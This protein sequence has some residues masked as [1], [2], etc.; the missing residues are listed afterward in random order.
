M[1]TS[2]LDR[3]DV[4]AQ[5]DQL[6][7]AVDHLTKP[8]VRMIVRDDG[9]ATTVRVPSL[10]SQALDAATTGSESSTPSALTLAER[11][12]VDLTLLEVR[13]LI[14]RCTRRWLLVRGL[15]PHESVP[16]QIRQL[17]S[18]VAT[19][20]IDDLWWW[21]YRLSSW[22]RLLSM[23]LRAG[24]HH[25]TPV[26]LRGAACPSCH[27]RRVLVDHGD[28][29]QTMPALVVDFAR[30]LVQAARCDACGATWWRGEELEHLATLLA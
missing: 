6:R 23:Y 21:E 17:A 28:G 27:A 15:V 16:L 29:P 20:E 4:A 8:D 19:H 26:R 14:A 9:T 13:E 10:W 2:V 5:L 12:L 3:L 24:E 25:P 7:R 30:G 11:N 22:A 1:T 18:H